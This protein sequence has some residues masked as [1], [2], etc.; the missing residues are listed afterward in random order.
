MSKQIKIVL[1]VGVVLVVAAVAYLM[2]PAG[3]PEAQ[4]RGL[5]MDQAQAGAPAE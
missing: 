4:G 5:T 1:A 2:W 3:E